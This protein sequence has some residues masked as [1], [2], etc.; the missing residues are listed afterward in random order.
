LLGATIYDPFGR[1][2]NVYL[3]EESVVAERDTV[4]DKVSAAPP[5]PLTVPEMLYV[6]GSVGVVV[7]VGLN[8]TSTQ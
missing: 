5:D 7:L 6:V 2:A 4:P 8:T 3:P 1:L